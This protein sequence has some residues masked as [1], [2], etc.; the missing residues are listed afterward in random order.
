MSDSGRELARHP[1]V[2]VPSCRGL[3]HPCNM[4]FIK[5]EHL[6][7]FFLKKQS[8]VQIDF[9]ELTFSRGKISSVEVSFLG[10]AVPY[11]TIC[12]SPGTLY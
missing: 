2:A 4:L 11:C 10:V 6:D 12:N 7:L 3:P 5:Q 1:A 9:D 8:C